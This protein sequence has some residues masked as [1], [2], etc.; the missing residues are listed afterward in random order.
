[1]GAMLALAAL[2]RRADDLD[3]A[4]R[5]LDKAH[6]AQ[7]TMVEPEVAAVE[8]TLS[9]KKLPSALTAAGAVVDDFPKNAS[10]LQ[11]LAQAQLANGR[12][13]DAMATFK[14]LADLQPDSAIEQF[15]LGSRLAALGNQD[16]AHA[17]Y[18]Q[19][20]K[21]DPHLVVGWQALAVGA[22]KAGRVDQGLD[23]ASRAAAI[24]P[25]MGQLVKAEVYAAAS[26]FAE[27]DAA[28]AAAQAKR[29]DGSVASRW[30]VVRAMSGDRAGASK[31]LAEWLAAH[32]DDD[33]VRLEYA[34]FL[35]GDKDYADSTRE[36]EA[37]L[38]K[39]PLNPIVLNNLAW[40][41]ARANNPKAVELARRAYAMA[42]ESPNVTD[43]LGWVLASRG[44]LKEAASLLARAHEQAPGDPMMSYHLAAV[45]AKQGE[46]DKAAS[47]LKPVLASGQPFD[48]RAHAEALEKALA[49]GR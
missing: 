30:A 12:R 42:P 5:W 49:S 6:A 37:L 26:R 25:R 2:A 46:R 38:K 43:T 8:L 44:D 3:G 39:A 10:A 17:A 19:A 28:F 41:Y 40:L 21:L 13:D 24:D 11:V 31:I 27:A 47:L 4:S 7:P 48:E 20:V 23:V 29:P 32:G 18:E 16:G 35:L 36:F 9:E 34:A 22:A 14:R 33:R 15:R 1:M 45:L